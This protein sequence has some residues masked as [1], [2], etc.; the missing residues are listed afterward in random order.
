MRSIRRL[1]WLARWSIGHKEE[2]G[3]G[4]NVGV[5]EAKPCILVAALEPAR[6]GS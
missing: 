6:M 2:K 4:L 5:L 1:W 3:A